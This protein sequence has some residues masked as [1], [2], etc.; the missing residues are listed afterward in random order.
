MRVM[1]LGMVISLM[2]VSQLVS[3]TISSIEPGDRVRIQGEGVFGEFTVGAV[4]RETL[5]LQIFDTDANIRAIILRDGGEIDLRG[6]ELELEGNEFLLR[7]PNG[8]E[9]DN[10]QRMIPVG[11]VLPC[12]LR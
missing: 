10:S 7:G 12:M 11:E 2:L 8:E 3:Q 9:G 4:Q 1:L 5:S 6:R